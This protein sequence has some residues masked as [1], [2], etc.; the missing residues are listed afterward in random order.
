MQETEERVY[1]QIESRWGKV[2]EGS[3]PRNVKQL[4]GQSLLIYMK[5]WD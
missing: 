5:A 4:G 2:K 1:S 3:L